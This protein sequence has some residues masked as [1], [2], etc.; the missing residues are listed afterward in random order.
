MLPILREL[1]L[2]RI[3]ALSG[4]RTRAGAGAARPQRFA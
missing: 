3:G 2:D 1:W 4:L